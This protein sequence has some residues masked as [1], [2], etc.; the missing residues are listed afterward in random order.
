MNR[1]DDEIERI[2]RIRDR[3][4]QLRDPTVKGRSVQRR[5]AA[6]YSPQKL[7]LSQTIREIPG[8]W[9]GMLLGGL[10]GILLGILLDLLVT[11]D[12]WWVCY[13]PYVVAFAGLAIGRML[14]AVL[15]W[16][17]QDHDALVHRR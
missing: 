15:D 7:T 1:Q 5:A 2:R 8:T 3:Q 17:E 11:I 10:V 14:G 16:R 4:L 6:R 12:D 9:L 13:V